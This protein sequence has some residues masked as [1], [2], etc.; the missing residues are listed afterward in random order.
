MGILIPGKTV[1]YWKDVCLL[2]SQALLVLII[3][4]RCGT[5]LLCV[6][7]AN[8]ILIRCPRTAISI[9]ISST[10]LIMWSGARTPAGTVMTEVNF[11]VCMLSG[12][13]DQCR[14]LRRQA[15]GVAMAAVWTI[16]ANS[17]HWRWPV[18]RLL[19]QSWKR[20]LRPIH[21]KLKNNDNISTHSLNIHNRKC[22]DYVYIKWEYWSTM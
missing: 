2:S 13:C 10:L 21:Y 20:W 6:W 22:Q 8:L 9:K 1:L 3:S 16:R 7:M 15:G 11:R 18:L 14:S 5:Y 4:S 19:T 12:Q 17:I